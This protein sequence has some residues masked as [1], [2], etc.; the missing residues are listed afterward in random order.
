MAPLIAIIDYGTRAMINSL[1]LL[2]NLIS[3]AVFS[4]LVFR[5]NSIS[6]YC[7]SLAI[8]DCFT[9][10]QLYA[11]ISLLFYDTYP[12]FYSTPICK[13]F[14][15]VQTAGACIPPWILVAF[16]FDKMLSM[17]L[18]HN[19]FE[20]MTKRWFQILLIASI[21]LFHAAIY[22]EIPILIGITAHKSP[23]NLYCD[24]SSMPSMDII[25]IVYMIDGGFL[26][27]VLMLT[28]SVIMIRTIVA[29]RRRVLLGA[30]DQKRASRDFKFAFTSITFNILFIVLK[31]PLAMYY[32]LSGA[33]VKIN[34][35]C[36]EVFTLLHFLN[37]SLSF[38]VHFASN[39]VFRKEL[40]SMIKSPCSTQLYHSFA[41]SPSNRVQQQQEQP[42]RYRTISIKPTNNTNNT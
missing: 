21:V 2:G 3:F 9:A 19:R 31:M 1:G 28:T 24:T 8:F 6:V 13:A 27:F 18:S 12:P 36:Y 41:S 10:M 16:S 34:P 20:I 15:Y 17:R 7:R 11:D 39:S 29:S 23:T 35:I 14:Y 4:R 38:V 40:F 22:V 30:N 37:S 32:V 5:K 25:S 33:G 26:P 42:Q